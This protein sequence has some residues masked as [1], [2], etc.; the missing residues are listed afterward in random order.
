MLQR[1]CCCCQP[2]ALDQHPGVTWQLDPLESGTMRLCHHTTAVNE[3]LAMCGDTKRNNCHLTQQNATS[4]PTVYNSQRHGVVTSIGG[5]HGDAEGPAMAML[6]APLRVPMPALS[7]AQPHHSNT[8]LRLAAGPCDTAD[9]LRSLCCCTDAHHT[10]CTCQLARVHVQTNGN[11]NK[12]NFGSRAG[13]VQCCMLHW[14][15]ANVLAARQ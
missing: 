15:A 12:D 6:R 10:K 7:K 3:A 1:S 8:A 14:L 5:H 2:A 13:R 11:G 9:E 4:A